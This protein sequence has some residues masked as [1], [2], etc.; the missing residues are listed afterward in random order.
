MK[1]MEEA[2]KGTD[3]Q[4]SVEANKCLTKFGVNTEE[5]RMKFDEQ[6][7]LLATLCNCEMAYVCIAE[8]EKQFVI[9]KVGFEPKMLEESLSLAKYALK[10]ESTLLIEDT[11]Q[12]RTLQ[13]N[14]LVN[15]GKPIRFYAGVPLKDQDG[16]VIGAVCVMDYQPKNL[17]SRKVNCLEISASKVLEALQYHQKSSS[18]LSNLEESYARDG[19]INVAHIQDTLMQKIVDLGHQNERVRQQEESLK[20]MNNLMAEKQRELSGLIDASPSC[21]AVINKDYCYEFTNNTYEQWFGFSRHELSGSPVTKVIGEELFKKVKIKFDQVFEGKEIK[22][23]TPFTPKGRRPQHFQIS[24]SP[25]RNSEG[26]VIGLYLFCEDITDLRKAQLQLENSNDDLKF[27]SSRASHDL[28]APLGIIESFSNVLKTDYE[29]KLDET[30]MQYLSFIQESAAQ[31]R[32]LITDLFAFARA[33]RAEDGEPEDLDLEE[34]MEIVNKN[35]HLLVQDSRAEL[36]LP[37]P[38]PKVR[39]RKSDAVQLFQNIITNA[40]KYKNPEV[41]PEIEIVY[42][43]AAQ[44][45]QVQVSIKDNGIGMEGEILEKIFDPF[46]RAYNPNTSGSG[47]GLA[48]CQKVIDYYSG[49]IWATSEPGNGSTFHFTLPMAQED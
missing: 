17:N 28:K 36:K 18:F 24:L 8:G 19:S 15:S 30:A 11:L 26:E 35:I 1:V 7:L 16:S 9:G 40:I 31:M 27:F 49:K 29:E 39:V 32:L 38:L 2:K 4:D 13:N 43:L 20:Y 6:M 37:K 33:G 14:P 5:A 21:I 47:I 42:D 23:E 46:F 44:D 25:K 3:Q 34:V 22:F 10:A 41:N 45:Q 48:T 12:H